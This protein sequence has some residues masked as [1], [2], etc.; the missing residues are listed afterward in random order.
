M[1]LLTKE[2]LIEV[3]GGSEK[4]TGRGW[5]DV[6]AETLDKAWDGLKAIGAVIHEVVCDE[7]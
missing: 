7:H 6:A 2:Q 4:T 3:Y 5:A 1:K